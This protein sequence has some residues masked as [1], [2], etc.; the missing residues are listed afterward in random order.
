MSCPSID[1][2][3]LPAPTAPVAHQSAEAKLRAY[4]TRTYTDLTLIRS[5]NETEPEYGVTCMHGPSECAGNVQQLCAAS[6]WIKDAESTRPWEDWWHVCR[7]PARLGAFF[8][9]VKS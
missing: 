6:H 7:K 2:T 1:A 5:V 3:A 8:A 9:C 4:L